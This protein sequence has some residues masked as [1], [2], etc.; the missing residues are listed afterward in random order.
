M[1]TSPKGCIFRNYGV[2]NSVQRPLGI[3]CVSKWF[4]ANLD[5]P[6]SCCAIDTVATE[7]C[8]QGLEIDMP[9]I[10]GIA[11]CFGMEMDGK[12]QGILGRY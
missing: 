9:L 2:D 4:N 6:K 12:I 11:I 5:H 10:G 3:F 7:F 8:C 1:I